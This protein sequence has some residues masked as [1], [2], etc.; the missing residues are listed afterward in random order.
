[1]QVSAWKSTVLSKGVLFCQISLGILV[2][3]LNFRESLFFL[4]KLQ[5]QAK[6]I[7]QLLKP[8]IL[9]PWSCYKQF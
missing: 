4:F 5:N 8:L 2:T 1:M 9:P 7:P 3:S 6:H